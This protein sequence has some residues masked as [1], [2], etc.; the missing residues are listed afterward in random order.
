MGVR[1]WIVRSVG[2][3]GW[4]VAV[5]CLAQGLIALNAVAFALVMRQA[6]DQAVAG[7]AAGFW[8]T[9]GLFGGLLTLQVVLRAL[10]RFA[11]ESARAMLDNRL[12]QRALHAT[13]T[14]DY[15]NASFRHSGDV[16]SRMTSDVAIVSDGVVSFVPSVVSLAIRLLAA[17]GALFVL[18]PVLAVVFASAGA[19]LV[20]V[21]IPA[22]R[23]FRPLHLRV[24]ETE[25]TVRCF[26]QE[27]LESLV[28]VHS[29]GCEDKVERTHARNQ[30]RH[31]KARTRRSVVV[32]MSNAGL[33][34]VL[35][36]GYLLGFVWCGVGLL[37]GSVTYGT[38]MAVIQLIGQVQSPFTTMGGAFSRYSA[39]LASAERLR[40]LEDAATSI[41]EAASA[42]GEEG[43]HP[44]VEE[45]AV[46]RRVGAGDT[47]SETIEELATP[48][49]LCG[50]LESFGLDRVSF[51]Y[52]SMRQILQ[53]CSF[54]VRAGEIVGLT[55]ESG[56][57]KSTVMLL[58][59][60]IYQPETGRAY[61]CVASTKDTASTSASTHSGMFA[62]VPQG[63]CLMSGT[64]REVVSFAEHDSCSDDARVEYACRVA[65]AWQFVRV[66]P[67]GLDTVL[68][69]RGAGLSEGQM[70]RLAVARAV[71][72][73]APILLLD[74]ATS[75]L[76]QQTEQHM[77]KNLKSLTGRT[78]LIVTHRP[79]ALRLCDRVIRLERG[80]QKTASGCRE[81]VYREVSDV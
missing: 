75:A 19:V 73:S 6:I 57:G 52:D 24:Q 32:S 35:Q 41:K 16:A 77:L 33:S 55:G 36:G 66:L 60:G 49:A 45:G 13:L 46:G 59:M 14:Q 30:E 44:C 39:M 67:D 26:V 11:E 74:E 3:C 54:R 1:R 65:C 17:F 43:V 70:Q 15:R 34:L 12:R 10:N 21:S 58:L 18:A 62:Y 38:M 48:H 2:S 76:D 42:R 47:R 69:E 5:L 78:V 63:N 28:V 53:S 50:D 23:L 68:G 64:V 80:A 27:C 72:S 31:R 40:D 56:S 9:V 8:L 29:F 71:Y 37:Q 81:D 4:L 22:R 79:E 20:L 61:V 7:N 51:G 25:S